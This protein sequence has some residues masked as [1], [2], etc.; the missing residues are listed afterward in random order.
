MELRSNLRISQNA[1]PVQRNASHFLRHV[2]VMRITMEF[3][4]K[5][6]RDKSMKS[7][8]QKLAPMAAP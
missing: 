2:I 1:A 8:L 4:R 3:R 7:P 5:L 6:T